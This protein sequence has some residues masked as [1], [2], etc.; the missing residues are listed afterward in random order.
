MTER[1]DQPTDL[2]DRAAAALRRAP[3]PDEP[4]PHVA[5]ATVEALQAAVSAE[6]A[7]IRERRRKMFRLARNGSAAAA[8]VLLLVVAAW[9][10]LMDRTAAPAFAD[11]VENVKNAKTAT[12]VTKLPTIIQG[13]QRGMLQQKWYVRDGAWR[14]EI[15]SAQGDFPAVPDLP[16]VLVAVV[17]DAAQ[18][19]AL[20]IDYVRK[21]AKWLPVDDKAWEQ[22]TKTNAIEQLR[23]LKSEDAER[24]GEEELNGAKTEAYRLKKGE[25]FMGAHLG[26]GETAKLWVDPKTGLPVRI[27]V[28]APAD[29]E[30]KTPQ[31]ILEQFRWNE[32]LDADLFKLEPPKDFKIEGE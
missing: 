30:D 23:K 19:K 7:R 21:T 24:L 26:R 32:P 8:A 27:V 31:I 10:F 25:T 4:P 12:F 11:V 2:V 14:T 5:A 29:A 15:P 1:N 28:D 13:S 3:A 16:P 9:L 18:K 6:I 20:Q 17:V 22:M